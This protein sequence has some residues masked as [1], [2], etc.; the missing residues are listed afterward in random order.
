VWTGDCA[1]ADPALYP[2]G[3]RGPAL[4]SNPAGTTSGT[5]ALGAVDVT[6]RRVLGTLVNNATV[7]GIHAA[8][9]GCPAGET[10]TSAT[11][12]ALGKLRLALPYGTW[13]IRATVTSGVPSI[14][15]TGISA[16]VVVTPSTVQAV[17]VVVLP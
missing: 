4:A 13:K 5:A 9:A 16:D 8:G 10:L 3:S 12:T 2:G 6:V 1:D 11:R 15:R 14:T 17:T 7:I